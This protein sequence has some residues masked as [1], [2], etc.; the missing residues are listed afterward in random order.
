MKPQF[1]VVLSFFSLFWACTEE[2]YRSIDALGRPPGLD[3]TQV[4]AANYLSGKA[5]EFDVSF[6]PEMDEV[7]FMP[8]NSKEHSIYRMQLI[9]GYWTDPELVVLADYPV[10]EG[11][12]YTN[13]Y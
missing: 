4:F 8:R 7:Y 10:A 1:L 11:P 6:S 2:D 9:N 12:I 5:Y 13:L 3:S